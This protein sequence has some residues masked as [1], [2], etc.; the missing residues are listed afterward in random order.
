MHEMSV[1]TS[2][3]EE[4]LSNIRRLETNGK[5]IMK[6]EEVTLEIGELAFISEMQLEFC[7]NLLAKEHEELKDSKLTIE[8]AEAKVRCDGCSFKGGLGSLEEPA[9]HRMVVSFA[10]PECGGTL[11]IEQGRGMILKNVS[12]QVE[13]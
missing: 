9:D 2:L 7:Y 12:V 1:A 13:D 10:C 11:D 8:K 3:I 5:N 6:V 4:I